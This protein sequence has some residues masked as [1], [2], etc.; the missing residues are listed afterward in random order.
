MGGQVDLR[1]GAP[2]NPAGGLSTPPVT[3]EA[4]QQAFGSS[5]NFALVLDGNNAALNNLMKSNDPLLKQFREGMVADPGR[6]RMELPKMIAAW[7]ADHKSFAQSLQKA[8]LF[9]EQADASGN[10]F[11]LRTYHQGDDFQR[12]KF[13]APLAKPDAAPPVTNPPNPAGQA[14]NK[15]KTAEATGKPGTAASGVVQDPGQ[16]TQIEKSF[17]ALLGLDGTVKREQVFKAGANFEDGIQE[18]EINFEELSKAGHNVKGFLQ[19][20]E[21]T[22]A[23]GA[24]IDLNADEIEAAQQKLDVGAA[25]MVSSGSA[26]SA[27]QAKHAI[28]TSE[29]KDLSEVHCDSLQEQVKDKFT[30]G[31]S[32]ASDIKNAAGGKI[33]SQDMFDVLKQL[34]EAAGN[35]FN[36]YFKNLELP[37][38]KN[39]AEVDGRVNQILKTMKENN[40]LAFSAFL[41][42]LHN[43]KLHAQDAQ[44]YRD[45]DFAKNVMHGDDYTWGE[46]RKPIGDAA[47]TTPTAESKAGA[48]KSW[49]QFYSDKV[50]DWKDFLDKAKHPDHFDTK[51]KLTSLAQGLIFNA[52]TG[53][54]TKDQEALKTYAE[55]IK[56]TN[57]DLYDQI[58]SAIETAKKMPHKPVPTQPAPKPVQAPPDQVNP[59][60]A[61]H[62]AHLGSEQHPAAKP[63]KAQTHHQHDT[64]AKKPKAETVTHPAQAPKTKTAASPWTTYFETGGT[65]LDKG[66]KLT[67]EATAKITATVTGTNDADK[68]DLAA[69][70]KSIKDTEPGK[71]QLITQ[72]I[73]DA[74]KAS[75]PPPAP[76]PAATATDWGKYFADT[77]NVAGGKLTNAALSHIT[78]V[79]KGPDG[80]DK[81]ALE[82]YANTAS[83]PQS[84]Q[85]KEAIAKAKA[86]VPE[87]AAALPL[88]LATAAMDLGGTMR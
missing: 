66:G 75:A 19:F 64:S 56:T 62:P 57:K 3:K 49:P 87:K 36:N 68:K 24:Q 83:N 22:S 29:L 7:D 2:P 35:S 32:R 23:S 47:S 1:L 45:T 69:Y 85:V 84:A 58:N 13:P 88:P 27:A 46:K 44:A 54:H 51:G 63:P 60:K 81:T 30:N 53:E 77:A 26:I 79:I 15:P 31:D 4:V 11:N 67:P 74:Q 50:I 28:V 48:D 82:A 14:D 20:I 55:S 25:L 37:D 78:E 80:A 9:L 70:V 8:G 41:I 59:P 52:Y 34:K 6:M 5:G 17:R 72:A 73:A 39:S 71:Y 86:P 76:A 40:P 16:Q 43:K 18:S 12:M 61:E 10:Y 65:A 42:A 33:T 38:G 21:H